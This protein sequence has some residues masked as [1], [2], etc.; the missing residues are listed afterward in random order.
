MYFYDFNCFYCFSFGP[1]P[2]SILV[3]TLKV[4]FCF[5]EN[6]QSGHVSALLETTGLRKVPKKK[7]YSF[8]NAENLQSKNK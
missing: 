6:V 4:L 5:K 8:S 1:L 7:D 2:C 3:C